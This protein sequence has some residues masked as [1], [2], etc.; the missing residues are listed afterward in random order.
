MPDEA[1]LARHK[2]M[3]PDCGDPIFPGEMIVPAGTGKSKW[4][5]DYCAERMLG[6][7]HEIDEDNQE[8]L[9]T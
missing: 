2:S 4:V 1:I 5:H 8:Q 3:C 7:E 9:P 6:P